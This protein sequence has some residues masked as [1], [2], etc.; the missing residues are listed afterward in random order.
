M[1]GVCFG[2][3]MARWKFMTEDMAAE[4]KRWMDTGKATGWPQGLG[5][6]GAIRY[7]HYWMMS[8]LDKYGADPKYDKHTLEELVDGL[9]RHTFGRIPPEVQ[10]V[11]GTGGS[12]ESVHPPKPASGKQAD[13]STRPAA[14]PTADPG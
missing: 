3:G 14:V 1:A 12:H 10:K 2:E 5:F 13:P 7:G 6:D 11:L 9:K 4:Y 8:W